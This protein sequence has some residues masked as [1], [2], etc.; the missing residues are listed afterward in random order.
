MINYE[1]LAILLIPTIGTIFSFY[2]GLYSERFRDFLNSIITGANL[3][4]VSYFFKQVVNQPMELY[5]RDIMGVGLHLKLDMFRYVF[6]WSTAFIWFLTTLY[7]TQYL[8]RYRH[9]NRYYAF[10]MTTYASTLGIFMSENLLN[11]FTFFEVMSLASYALVIHDEDAY[12]HEAGRSYISMALAGGLTLLMG[13]LLLYYYS[14]TLT[15]SDFDHGIEY[16]GRV[17]YVIFVLIFVGFGVKSSVVPLHCWLPKAHPAAPTPASAILSGILIKTGIFGIII[18]VWK[19]MWHDPYVPFILIILGCVNI[20]HG[21]ILAM[22][23]RNIKRILAYSSMSQAGYVLMGIGLAGVLGDHGGLAIVGTLYHI[24]NHAIFKVLLFMGVGI[25]YVVLHE[26]SINKIVGF[27][28]NKKYLKIVFMLGFLAIIGV[29]GTNGFISKTL[30]HEALIEA[31]HEHLAV[32]FTIVEYIFVIGGSLTVAYLLKIFVTVF[33]KSSDEFY[34]QFKHHVRKRALFPMAVLGACIVAIGLKPEILFNYL[35]GITRYFGVEPPHVIEFY[36]ADTVMGFVL[37][38]ILGWAVYYVYVNGYL[39]KEVDGK[40]IYVN[41]SLS[42]IELENDIYRP[43][44]GL[45]FIF[46]STLL[47]IVDKGVIYFFV[48]IKN[49]FLKL[50][51]IEVNMETATIAQR[52]MSAANLSVE[53]YNNGKQQA[54]HSA[55]SFIEWERETYKETVR[56]SQN[57]IRSI[58]ELFALT[59]SRLNSLVYTVI[60][61]IFVLVMVLIVMLQY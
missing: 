11:F 58:K 26:L 10:F 36:T 22:M 46:M 21:G 59:S 31:K 7:S 37:P 14:G 61:F 2:V 5:I 33:M 3:L 35:T 24:F 42:W 17:R 15:I 6:V 56:R 9:R 23:Q 16:I 32:F 30:L 27:G 41:P 51:H 49:S 1:L 55:Q 39:L 18:L 47:R 44:I 50:M 45:I 25:I 40:A 54:S 57:K 34:G 53:R 38:F 13:L 20:L 60:T 48:A 43:V 19:L 4:L 29:P 28:T 52:T 12:S 8:I